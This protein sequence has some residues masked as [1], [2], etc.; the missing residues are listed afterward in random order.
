M[1]ADTFKWLTL[2][3]QRARGMREHK[4]LVDTK[5]E[6]VA[7]EHQLTLADGYFHI[8][9]DRAD[10][11]FDNCDKARKALAELQA[12]MTRDATGFTERIA[13]Y[14]NDCASMRTQIAQRE[15]K[16]AQL[17]K[18]L[19]SS[20]R[21]EL[22]KRIADLESA[23]QAAQRR[24][25]ELHRK[26]EVVRSQLTQAQDSNR[27]LSTQ[28]ET[29]KRE[30]AREINAHPAV[31]Q[32]AVLRA[33]YG[34]A[35]ERIAKLSPATPEQLKLQRSQ[36]WSEIRNAPENRHFSDGEID[37]LEATVTRFQQLEL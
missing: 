24:V 29:S 16:I 19:Q 20:A 36:T 23:L 15:A 32:L 33:D 13:K 8:E 9:K 18:N 22:A 28:L 11:N 21:G 25:Q 6:I 34:I 7:L 27:V 4:K 12:L 37:Q 10:R 35:L 26:N 17:E 31:E 3:A 5:K 30:R 14:Q 1:F 2:R